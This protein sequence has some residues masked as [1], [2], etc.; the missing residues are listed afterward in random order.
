MIQETNPDLL[1]ELRDR[2]VLEERLRGTGR[3]L[4]SDERT[5]LIAE[6]F[7]E[8]SSQ[9][10]QRFSGDIRL[11]SLSA[12]ASL[13][14]VLLA[15]AFGIAGPVSRTPS[16]PVPTAGVVVGALTILSLLGAV[17][18]IA[19]QS[20]RYIKRRMVPLLAKALAPLTPTEAE[21]TETLATLKA[22]GHKIG[23]KLKARWILEATRSADSLG[24]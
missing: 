11:D 7:R 8:L 17:G 1:D 20:P 6:P 23:R 5:A 14:T 4:T 21:L 22:D 12:Y 13:A 15:V 19:T 24:R 18:L 2:L 3:P 9:V 16:D 10:E